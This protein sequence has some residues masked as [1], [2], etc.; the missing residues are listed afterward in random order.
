[1]NLSGSIHVKAAIIGGLW[2][3]G[4]AFS[5]AG[6]I[7]PRDGWEI[8]QTEKP[9]ARLLDDFKEVVP[10]VGMA[11]VTEAG[12]TEAAKARDVDIPGNRVIGVFDN[13]T[14]VRLLKLSTPAMIEA[15]IRFYVTEDAEGRGRLSWKRPSA[16]L[17]TYADGKNG[18]AISEI[19]QSLDRVFLAIAER[20]TATDE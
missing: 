9:Y 14:A 8:R 10:M 4:S 12:P 13:D 2:L 11:V 17:A 1:M 5:Y 6:P 20:A 3:A 19:G 7:E 15:P 16:I 18:D